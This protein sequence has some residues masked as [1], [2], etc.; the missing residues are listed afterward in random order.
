MTRSAWSAGERRLRGSGR[1]Y[2]GVARDTLLAFKNVREE[3]A[4]LMGQAMA[5]AG[6][7]L[8]EAG[9]VLVPLHR[10]RLWTRG[11]NQ[12]VLLA[13]EVGQRTGLP[14]QVDLLQRAKPTLK[15][16][17]LSKRARVRN[18]RGVFRVP[19]APRAEL[20][21]ARVVLVD[22]VLT[23]GAKAGAC[24]RLLRRAGAAQVDVLTYAR[25]APTDVTA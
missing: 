1:V 13:L 20:A 2:A 15:S 7:T 4:G 18:V 3:L 11:Y 17:G 21:G 9:V 23:S 12:S 6:R 10:W 22:D 5:R 16:N 8:L 14:V 19:L 25:V 24:A